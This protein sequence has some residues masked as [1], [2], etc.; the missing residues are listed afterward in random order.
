MRN[1]FGLDAQQRT[2]TQPFHTK[3]WVPRIAH[4][5]VFQLAL[6]ASETRLPLAQLSLALFQASFSLVEGLL[7]VQVLNVDSS[8]VSCLKGGRCKWAVTQ[9]EYGV[10][11]QPRA[12]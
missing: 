9:Y 2:H 8:T 4:L 11:L 6:L 10:Y 7:P 3:C 5:V 1:L 12:A